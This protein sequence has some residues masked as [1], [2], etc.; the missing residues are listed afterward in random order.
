M[1]LAAAGLAL[2]GGQAGCATDADVGARRSAIVSGMVDLADPE[3]VAVSLAWEDGSAR[4]CTGTLVSPRIV[5]TAAHCLEDVESALRFQIGF[6]TDSRTVPEYDPVV[7]SDA[8]D[9]MTHPDFAYGTPTDGKDIGLVLLAEPAVAAPKPMSGLPPDLG[10]QVRMVGFG[11][12]ERYATDGGLKRESSA[13]VT[14]VLDSLFFFGTSLENTCLGDSG[15]PVYLTVLGVERLVGISSFGDA[16]CRETTGATRVDSYVF[17]VIYPWILDHDPDA[18]PPP[19]RPPAPPPDGGCAVAARPAGVPP[20]GV[21]AATTALAY[22]LVLAFV[23]ARA[24][25]RARARR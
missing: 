3:V 14:D 12:T 10:E 7:W 1:R 17:D 25:A 9:H 22:A 13:P 24:R 16:I 19:E 5:L 15:G 6:G 11:R 20:P 8:V 23:R 4:L 18:P 21:M 2:L